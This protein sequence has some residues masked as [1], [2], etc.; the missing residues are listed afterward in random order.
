MRSVSRRATCVSGYKDQDPAA[1][2]EA[3]GDFARAAK[4]GAHP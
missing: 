1:T 2:D 4:A 3:V